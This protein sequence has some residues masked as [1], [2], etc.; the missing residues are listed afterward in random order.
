[1]AA[2][3]NAEDLANASVEKAAILMLSL[4]ADEAA[5]IIEYLAPREVRKLGAAMSTIKA[6]QTKQL[7]TVLTDFIARTCQS[8]SLGVAS[9][10]YIR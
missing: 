9:D 4:G 6:V 10:E 5:E 8:T 1:M 7:N 3:G 2:L